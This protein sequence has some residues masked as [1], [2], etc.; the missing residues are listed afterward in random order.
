M[1]GYCGYGVPSSSLGGRQRLGLGGGALH[2]VDGLA[3]GLKEVALSEDVA[4][5]LLA[6][7]HALRNEAKH[8]VGGGEGRATLD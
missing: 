6:S 4:H 8:P 7:L 2:E 1:K 3:A 5:V